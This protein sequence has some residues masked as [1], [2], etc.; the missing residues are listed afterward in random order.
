MMD[1]DSA[2]FEPEFNILTPMNELFQLD[3]KLPIYLRTSSWSFDEFVD[4][5]DPNRKMK[6]LDIRICRDD[7]SR[8][9]Y[10]ER[11]GEYDTEEKGFAR[12]P[13]ISIDGATAYWYTYIYKS[14]TT[15]SG[16]LYRAELLIFHNDLR[17]NIQANAATAP[18]LAELITLLVEKF[19]WFH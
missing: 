8:D 7:D 11:L 6:S 16:R 12:Q 15:P 9:Y 1:A 5:D 4:Y 18:A 10:V 3:V 17:V 2:Y 13:P 19:K 14:S